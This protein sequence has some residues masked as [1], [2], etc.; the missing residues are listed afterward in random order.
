LQRAA[1]TARQRQQLFTGGIPPAP[2]L[3]Q[4]D[5]LRSRIL[6]FR[7]TIARAQPAQ[8]TESV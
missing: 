3:K 7:E 5:A 2:T 6:R 1:Q 8:E 4:I